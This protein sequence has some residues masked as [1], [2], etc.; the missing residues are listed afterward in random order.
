V[1]QLGVDG[2]LTYVGEETLAHAA[3]AAA[4]RTGEQPDELSRGLGLGL[5]AK[6][7]S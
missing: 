4:A 6:G 3:P 1:L 2:E 5:A 7:F